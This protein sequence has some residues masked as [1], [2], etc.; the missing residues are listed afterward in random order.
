MGGEIRFLLNGA[1]RRLADVAPT[2]TVLDYLRGAER[3]CGT[4]EGCAEGDCGACTIA[5]GEPAG[6]GIR[7]RAIN[8]CVA[9]LPQIDGTILLTVEGLAGRSSLHPV[10]QAMVDNEGSQCGFC[11]PG[12]VMAL[13]AFQHGGEAADEE[14]VHEALA[15]N[16]CR[17]TGYRPI[18][19]AARQIAGKPDRFDAA[20]S[21][22][23]DAL[24]PL[25]RTE[26]IALKHGG[27]S[28]FAPASLDRLLALRAERPA[29]HL[30]A[31]GTDLALLVTKDYRALE[32][33]ILVTRVPELREIKVEADALTLGAAVTYTDA[34][35][36]IE[37]HWP[38]LARLVKRIGS[39]QIRNLG[40]IGGNIANASP[41]GD[42]PPGLIAL[43]AT[44]A[45]RSRTGRRVLP[46][47]D[48]FLDYRRTALAK[49]EIVE[50][51]RIPL[52]HGEQFRTYKI[53]KRWDQDIS[54]VCG[55]YSITLDGS[56]I[57]AAR[58]VYGGMAAT[59]RRAL[60][61]EHALIGRAWSE[62]AVEMAAAALAE[63]FHPIGD[64]RASAAYRTQVAGNL[65]RRFWLE[66]VRSD[67]PLD[68]MAL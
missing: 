55:A 34:L 3:A 18:V 45:L 33:V 9:F 44:V 64:W 40:T 48:F 21:A 41:I 54:A 31:G 52:P 8:A 67:L 11:T 47:E 59:P 2:T 7:W 57:A 53:A 10:Q 4:K 46:L 12:F 39:R 65:L 35:P 51:V 26:E 16:L 60:R 56:R 42:M 68:V 5:L 14:A 43:G 36:V 63:D 66:T 28:F 17:C 58:I 24:A 25:R 19:A 38:S 29:A 22:L 6:M 62:A 30:L 20:E 15:G 37:R 13:F 32:S 50:A 27:E 49:D 23:L 1:P 61:A